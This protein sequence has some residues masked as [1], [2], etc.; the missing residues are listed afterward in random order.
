MG[1]NQDPVRHVFRAGYLIA[2]LPWT[3]PSNEI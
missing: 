2:A 3:N 1:K